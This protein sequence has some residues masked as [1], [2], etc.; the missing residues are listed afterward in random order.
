MAFQT[1]VTVQQA[2]NS[3]HSREYVLPAI[4]REFVWKP[5]QIIK[6][7]DSLLTGYPIGS[8]LFW[9]VQSKNKRNFQFY[10]FIQHYHERDMKHNPKAG[11]AG[12]SNVTAILDGQQRLTALYLGLRGTYSDR[13]RYGRWDSDDAFPPKQLYL[14]LTEPSKDFELT[15]DLSFRTDKADHVK[16]NGVDYIRVGKVLDFTDLGDVFDFLREHNLLGPQHPQRALTA[17]L[18]AVNTRPVINYY[19]ESSQDLDKVLTIFIRVN[20]AGTVLS[21]SDLLLSI[22]TAEWKSLDARDEIQRLVDE[23][24]RIGRGFAFHKD[25]VLKNC[26]MLTDLE[27]RFATANFSSENMAVIEEKWP[28]ISQAIRITARLLHGFGFSAPT[29]PSINA[30]IPIVYYVYKRGNPANIVDASGFKADRDRIRRWL[31]IALLKRTFTGQPDSILRAVRD[32]LK[33]D[34]ADGFPSDKIAEALR[35]KPRSMQFGEDEV[36]AILDDTYSSGYAFSILALLYPWL[37]FRNQ[38]HMDHI[39]PKSHF[40]RS[41][42]TRR[43]ITDL[44]TIADFQEK[45]DRIPNLQLLQGMPNIEKSNKS[46]AEWLDEQFPL[47]DERRAY[48]QQH[49]IPDV[50]PSLT[51]FGD[52]YEA[53]R[54]LMRQRLRG[55]VGL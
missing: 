27:T 7:F 55:I 34:H 9:E 5:E 50:N 26:L 8:F 31:N 39:H 19:I 47:E 53:R 44:Q 38:F 33:A 11:L 42:L 51:S 35:L 54:E 17:L 20:S 1:P 45:Y 3:I 32:V 36:E 24:N 40:T 14:N 30:V 48:M 10:D 25:F 4:Q 2:V 28:Q 16:E 18:F 15:Y 37:D 52:F 49:Y 23:I 22:A 13:R 46:F 43:G 12:D 6:L 41:Q 21:Y 29:L